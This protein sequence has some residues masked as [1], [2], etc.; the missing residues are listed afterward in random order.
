MQAGRSIGE[1][2]VDGRLCIG[3]RLGPG[4][5]RE[6]AP[7]ERTEQIVEE[8]EI[9]EALGVEA[10]SRDG[11]VAVAVVARPPVV[12]R[13]HLVGLRDLAKARLGI[14][15]LGDIGMQL[16]REHA[17]GLLDLAIGRVAAHAEQLVVVLLRHGIPDSTAYAVSHPLP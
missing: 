15:R 6:T 16:A 13:E 9:H 3:S 4:R 17:E 7:E 2:D 14:G 11:L 12:V 8:R 10:L 5:S 1:I